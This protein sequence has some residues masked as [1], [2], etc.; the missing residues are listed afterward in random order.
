MRPD[1]NEALTFLREIDPDGPHNL[2]ASNPSKPRGSR[3]AIDGETYPA[4]GKALTSYISDHTERRHNVYYSLA[5][6]ANVAPNKKLT[7]NEIAYLRGAHVDIDP[8]KDKPFPAARNELAERVDQYL[9]S[10]DDP[11]SSDPKP[12]FVIDSGGGFQFLY[13]FNQPLPNTPENRETVEG[14]N[15]ALV[16]KLGGDA[17]THNVDR[18]LRLPG[19][20]NFPDEKKAE[21]GQPVARATIHYRSDERCDPTA[22]KK[23]IGY[24]AQPETEKK[25]AEE[26]AEI[27]TALKSLKGSSALDITEYESL[28]DNLKHKFEKALHSYPDLKALWERGGEYLQSIQRKDGQI[29][30]TSGSGC[31]NALGQY[32]RTIGLNLEEFASLVLTWDHANMAKH[33]SAEDAYWRIRREISRSYVKGSKTPPITDGSEFGAANDNETPNSEQPNERHD[34]LAETLRLGSYVCVDPKSIPPRQTLLPHYTIGFYGLLVAPG[35]IGKSSIAMAEALAIHTAKNLLNWK[36]PP[37]QRKVMYI[38]EDPTDEISRRIEALRI[39]HKLTPSDLDGLAVLSVRQFDGSQVIARLNKGRPVVDKKATQLIVDILIEREIGVLMLDPYN[40]F[41][42]LPENDNGAMALM[43]RTLNWIAEKAGV[44]IMLISHS[45]KVLDS[46]ATEV[47][48]TRGA[49]AIVDGARSARTV[50]RMSKKDAPRFGIDP[51]RARYFVRIDEEG[52]KTNLM[53][54]TAGQ[55]WL[56]LAS[57]DLDN[58]AG[59]F[60]ADHIQAVKPFKIELNDGPFGPEVRDGVLS[61]VQSEEFGVGNRAANRLSDKV[62]ELAGL[63]KNSKRD[64]DLANEA[65]KQWASSGVLLKKTVT[66]ADRKP[67]E[68]W[69]A[70]SISDGSEFAAV[71]DEDPLALD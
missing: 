57:V 71:D 47:A 43:A 45:R 28:P 19:T 7:T 54:A 24:V 27:E 3:G 68:I 51:T 60:K 32:V 9:L 50:I 4:I 31:R 20:V 13:L 25:H 36:T 48:D 26:E 44:A 6:P 1:L 63:D 29:R 38:G 16:Q 11:L 35:G 30:D 62:L 33:M 14:I 8:P 5:K 61:A 70:G 12:N 23:T 21:R 40:A 64:K 17:G 2:V 41:H 37:I 69:A 10:L 55:H 18:V 42:E 39:E 65:I 46:S 52:A 56:Q 22:L 59:E 67:K 49:S 53:P 34:K 15:R 58:A 66:G